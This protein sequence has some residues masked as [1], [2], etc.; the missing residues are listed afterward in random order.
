[1]PNIL[2]QAWADAGR[3]AVVEQADQYLAYERQRV[4]RREDD[5]PALD[6]LRAGRLE[7]IQTL[8]NLDDNVR[9]V[10]LDLV[11][12][13]FTTE[14]GKNFLT[15]GLLIDILR[16]LIYAEDDA[17]TALGWQITGKVLEQ[18]TDI[19]VARG[20]ADR[21]SGLPNAEDI[22]RAVDRMDLRDGTVAPI[23]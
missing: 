2:F 22:A 13:L 9:T 6:E 19:A 12:Y 10:L 1:M 16:D 5:A 15:V 17:E 14:D 3:D 18:V 7:A 21:C 20:I 8:A 4:E 23:L 11:D